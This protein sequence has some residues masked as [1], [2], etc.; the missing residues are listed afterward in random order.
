[1][2]HELEAGMIVQVIDVALGTCEKIIC[3]D[4]F[5]ALLQQSVDKVRSEKTCASRDENALSAVINT[6]QA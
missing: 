1:M 5:M 3:T 4:H 2:P 6:G